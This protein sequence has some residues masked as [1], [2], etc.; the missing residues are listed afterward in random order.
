MNNLSIHCSNCL[1]KTTHELLFKT[2]TT[3]H[4]DKR[5]PDY[6]AA[7]GY[8]YCLYECCGCHNVVMRKSPWCTE[9]FP[10]EYTA[11]DISWYPALVSRNLPK[12]HQ[13]LPGNEQ[14]LLKEI[15]LV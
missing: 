11:D 8:E 2:V 12:W 13:R 10:D 7:Q 6:V 15:C 5:D 9:I 14:K 1:R 3:E 4:E